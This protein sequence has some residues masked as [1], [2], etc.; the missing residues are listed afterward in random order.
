MFNDNRFMQRAPIKEGDEIEIAI[1][2]VGEKGDGIGRV[3]GFVVFIP[4]AQQGQTIKVR[5]T[6]VLKKFAFGEISGEASADA[7]TA[8][9]TSRKAPKEED[10]TAEKGKDDDN[11]DEEGGEDSEQFG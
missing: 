7:P 8:A 6:K 2:S 11:F 3:K 1:E 4:G 5:I 10:E 9:K